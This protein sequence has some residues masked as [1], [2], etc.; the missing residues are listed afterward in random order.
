MEAQREGGRG[1]GRGYG[2]VSSLAMF[3]S[4]NPW[5]LAER[6]FPSP[7]R[8]IDHQPPPPFWVIPF[9]ERVSS[10]A[11]SLERGACPDLESVTVSVGT[12]LCPGSV[13][14]RAYGLAF[15]WTVPLSLGSGLGAKVGVGS[16]CN[17]APTGP[18]SA[19]A[20]PPERGLN[21]SS[22]VTSLSSLWSL[23]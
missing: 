6:P 1:S 23:S 9:P 2:D 8:R 3:L 12:L 14:R 11:R 21:V 7:S 18:R 19:G 16:W 4:P 15:R 22:K 10:L 17:V 20:P 5:D 13:C